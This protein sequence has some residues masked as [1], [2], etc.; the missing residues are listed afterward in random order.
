VSWEFNGQSFALDP[1]Q[2]KPMN[3]VYAQMGFRRLPV[4][5]TYDPAF[6]H[7]HQSLIGIKEYPEQFPCTPIEQTANPEAIDRSKLPPDRQHAFLERQGWDAELNRLAGRNPLTEDAG[8][9]G[10]MADK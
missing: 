4:M 1:H 3:L 5:G 7:Q 10:V 9:A 6:E 2:E 8:F